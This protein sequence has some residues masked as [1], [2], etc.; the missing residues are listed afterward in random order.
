MSDSWKTLSQEKEKGSLNTI[1][2]IEATD[3]DYFH[4]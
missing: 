1:I 4:G 3:R 2:T